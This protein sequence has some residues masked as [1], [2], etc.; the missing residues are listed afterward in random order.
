MDG[1]DKL[2]TDLGGE[3][4]IARPLRI[5]ASLGVS[6]LVVVAAEARHPAVRKVA[7]KA[8]EGLAIRCVEGGHR[9]QDSVA[10]GLRAAPEADFYLIHD[11]ARP[12]ISVEL[13]ERVLAAARAHAA[14]IPALPVADTIKRVTESGDVVETLD[15]APL[16]AAQTP[17]A[18]AGELLRRA[19]AEVRQDVTDDASMVEALGVRVATVPGDTRNIKVTSPGDLALVRAMLRLDQ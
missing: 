16:R 6:S 3:P 17:Q 12:L 14:A 4:L 8:T 5:L 19:H 15:R 11:G 9:R 10:A 2:W 7:A 18:F 13:C 1:V